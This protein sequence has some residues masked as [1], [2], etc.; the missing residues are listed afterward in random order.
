MT[1][2]HEISIIIA[3]DHQVVVEGLCMVLN[4]VPKMQVIAT[5][6]NGKELLDLLVNHSPQLILLDIEM[7][8]MDGLA[9]CKK[10]KANYPAIKIL[11]L[12]SFNKGAVIQQMIKNGAD[13]Y[14]LKNKVSEELVDAIHTILKG[15]MYVDEEANRALLLSIANRPSDSSFR[16]SLTKREKQV[17]HLIVQEFNTS[18]IAQELFLSVNTIESHRKNLLSKLGAKNVAGLV[19]IAM[20]RGYLDK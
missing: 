13:G 17:L 4:D 15:E 16:P 18:E 6:N 12:S 11:V 1:S 2:R 14:V 20:E 19:R 7:P 8:V 3:D 10:I 5:A 9:V